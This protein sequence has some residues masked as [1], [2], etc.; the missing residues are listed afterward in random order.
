MWPQVVSGGETLRQPTESFK[1]LLKYCFKWLNFAVACY[2][3]ENWHMF[4]AHQGERRWPFCTHSR[5]RLALGLQACTLLKLWQSHNDQCKLP[6]L[7][8]S[9]SAISRVNIQFWQTLFHPMAQIHF[10][11]CVSFKA[12]GDEGARSMILKVGNCLQMLYVNTE[13]YS[14]CYFVPSVAKYLLSTME[15]WACMVEPNSV[16]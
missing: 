13:G 12:L 3:V 15:D 7:F 1:S 6:F 14:Y 5:Y 10:C 11:L 2:I 4:F 16:N 8:T 9:K